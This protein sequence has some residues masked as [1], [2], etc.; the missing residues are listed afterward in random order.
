MTLYADT[1]Q[2]TAGTELNKWVILQ[3]LRCR[4]F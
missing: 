1:N 3:E 2:T 4:L